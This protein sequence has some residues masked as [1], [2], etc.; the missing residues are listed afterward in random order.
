MAVQLTATSKCPMNVRT[1]L[2]I[3]SLTG[4][5]AM[6][7]A[8]GLDAPVTWSHSG[9]PA[10]RLLAE[11]GKHV[12]AGL[13]TTPQTAGDVLVVRF[14]DLPLTDVMRH[15]ART[16][17]AEWREEPTGW[18]LMRGTDAMRAL[19]L[20]ELQRR[21]DEV[22]A[23]I[24]HIAQ[25]EAE[26]P[27]FQAAE[28][29]ARQ[30]RQREEI[31]RAV[32]GGLG[33][34]LT[35]T[36]E[37]RT[38]GRQA[39][40]DLL[41]NLDP[42]RLGGILPGQRLVFATA[43]TRMQL[44]LGPGSQPILERFM[45]EQLEFQNA[46]GGNAVQVVSGNIPRRIPIPT[47][48]DPRKGLGKAY[49]VASRIRDI[50]TIELRVLDRD[51]G[52]ISFT[53]I[54]LGLRSPAPAEKPA[55]ATPAKLSPIS[56]EFL[57]A[58]RLPTQ[59]GGPRTMV[60][61]SSSTVQGFSITLGGETFTPAPISDDLRRR[62]MR[63]DLF[64]PLA[65]GPGEALT[66]WAEARDHQLVAL[67]PDALASASGSLASESATVESFL[68]QAGVR[69]LVVM[70][71][72]DG[73]TLVSP[74]YPVTS[75][76]QRVPRLPLARLIDAA[77]Q[78]GTMSLNDVAAYA[79]AYPTAYHG[80]ATLD[81]VLLSLAGH[82]LDPWTS[83]WNMLRLFASLTP[84]QKHALGSEQGLVIG[85]L[86]QAQIAMLAGMVYQAMGVPLT[87]HDSDMPQIQGLPGGIPFG[88]GDEPTDVLPTGIPRDGRI[89]VAVQSNAVV[90]ASHS[91]SGSGRTL[92][93][94]DLA[95]MRLASE[96]PNLAQ[97]AANQ[98]VFDLFRLGTAVTYRFTFL[99]TETH[100]MSQ[101]LDDVA[102]ASAQAVPYER[103]PVEFR[104][105]VDAEM[106]RLRGPLGNIQIGT[107]R[108]GT[109]P[110]TDEPSASVGEGPLA[111]GP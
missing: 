8:T 24:E 25:Q 86:S 45:R 32:S 77:T 10:D 2:T 35:S 93:P 9:A 28:E 58:F 41:K 56:V 37:T 89:L 90:R 96:L 29:A 27:P 44:P 39:A 46:L 99:L 111:R 78:K 101:T 22:R 68:D 107:G 82:P 110:P 66:N 53:P 47:A 7:Q 97:F 16:T 49:L 33:F 14:K 95:S 84:A 4:S 43:P 72:S 67:L 109:P 70:E 80:G 18:R 94:S 23:A 21:T 64:E 12:G 52:L 57:R 69:Q 19:E 73:A 36:A 31:A 42:T 71:E 91:V 79:A 1:L 26:A 98:P 54:S 81:T 50:L 51:G 34:A 76:R 59:P 105:S 13:W 60:S 62:A 100:R 87:R 5:L 55:G 85:N 106:E 88:M 61:V 103:L 17:G 63:P 102:L 48:G 65:M 38:P 83:R 6:G 74:R 108:P 15:I 20:L 75:M 92:T 104:K 30:Q 11:L 3:G 40:I